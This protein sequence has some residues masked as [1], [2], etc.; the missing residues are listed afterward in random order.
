[1]FDSDFKTAEEHLSF[2]FRRCHC[3]AKQNKRLILLYLLPVKMLL[4][5]MPKC[6]LLK[7]Y[8]LEQFTDLAT[9]VSTG[10]LLQL[11]DALRRNEEFFVKCGIY[12]I[13]E[14]LKIITYRN[15]FKK[16]VQ[17]MKTHQIPI[18][19]F[20]TALK[21]MKEDDVDDDEVEC[22]IANLIFENKIKGYISHQHRKL[23][24]SKQNAFPPIASLSL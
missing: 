19:A 13:L 5:H 6:S 3:Q 9:A 17:I 16:V 18:G 2:A 24:I 1:M 12:L 22:L 14:K 7:K 15:L 10:N 11:N 8:R 4:G 23:I 20:T 21:L